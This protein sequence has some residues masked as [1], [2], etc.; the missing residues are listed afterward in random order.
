MAQTH[1]DFLSKRRE[2]FGAVSKEILTSHKKEEMN[3]VTEHKRLLLPLLLLTIGCTG[4]CQLPHFGD[5]DENTNDYSECFTGYDDRISFIVEGYQMHWDGFSPEDLDLSYIYKYESP[6]GGFVKHDLDGDGTPELLMGEQ[7]GDSGYQIYDIFTFDKTTGEIIHL[8][9]GGERDWCTFNGSGIIIE[10]GS[11]SAFDSV[12]NYYVIKN[13]KLKK[14]GRNLS[15]TDDILA[16]NLDKFISYA[17]PDQETLCGGYTRQHG[18]SEEDL[19][20]FRK[21]MGE[22]PFTPLSVATQVVAGL[23]YRFLCTGNCTITIFQPLQG[24][25]VVSKIQEENGGPEMKVIIDTEGYVGRY[26]GENETSY[27]GEIQDT[28]WIDKNKARIEL[29][30]ASEGQ[31]IITLENFG[32]QPVFCRPDTKSDVIGTMIFE[33]GYVPEVYRCLGYACGWFLTDIDGKSGFIREELVGWDS[34]NSF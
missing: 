33:Q 16:L 32:T 11:N 28:Y 27:Q 4:S 12:T 29:M 26:I 22:T 24:E 20:L 15:I 13:L 5:K 18:L 1:L 2:E 34:I 21:V 10:T 17:K 25:P 19:A 31:G 7:S 9:C 23:N 8:F 14:L 30:K 6:N 3:T